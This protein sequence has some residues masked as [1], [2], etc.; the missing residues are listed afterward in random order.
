LLGA[1]GAV[2][3]STP[4][5]LALAGVNAAYHLKAIYSNEWHIRALEAMR[6]AA[7]KDWREWQTSR[8]TLLSLSYALSQKG[9][10]TIRRAAAAIPGVG[11]IGTCY[12][13]GRA[14]F[15]KNKGVARKTHAEQLVDAGF[16]WNGGVY[17]P[18]YLA[19]AAC[20][21]LLG[22]ADFAYA[23]KEDSKTLKNLKAGVAQKLRST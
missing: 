23:V 1:A 17:R 8:A 11:L 10:K 18:D 13:L 22:E 21:E 4:V 12:T 7:D 19:V 6:G 15:K 16:A 2:A 20:I 3:A 14:V 9:E 5:G